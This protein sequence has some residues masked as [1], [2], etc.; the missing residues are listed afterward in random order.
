MKS[1]IAYA[2]ALANRLLLEMQASYEEKAKDRYLYASKHRA[3]F[4]RLRIQL[5]KELL[6]IEKYLYGADL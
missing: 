4:S 1:R 5:A 3:E 6:S 2:E